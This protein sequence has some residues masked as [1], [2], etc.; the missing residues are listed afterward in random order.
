MIIYIIVLLI[1]FIPEF[2]TELKS[3]NGKLLIVIIVGLFICFGYM[4]G[5]DWR[6]YEEFYYSIDLNYPFNN[7]PFE[8]G[9]YFYILLFRY[10]NFDFW[11][12]FIFTKI[13]LYIINI[14]FL[15]KYQKEHFYISF[16]IYIFL[17]G[18]SL[19][20]DNPMRTLIA[21]TIFLFSYK[22]LEAGNI[23]TYFFIV[24]LASSF[25][26]VALLFITLYW[27]LR[28]RFVT[29]TLIISFVLFNIILW[30]FDTG[31]KN[32]FTLN[33]G[34]P[35]VDNKLNFYFSDGSSGN[36]YTENRIVS[37]GLIVR[38]V[39]FYFVLISRK[40]IE[41]KYGLIFFN[42]VISGFF[43]YR[44]AIGIPIFERF[45][46][47]VVIP[48]CVAI[49]STIIS[50][51]PNSKLI[52]KLSLYLLVLILMVK[53]I[54]MD[55]KYIPYTNYLIYTFQGKKLSF[56]E[57]SSYNFVNSPYKKK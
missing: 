27:L 20:I 43:F 12:F 57:R 3:K 19:Y 51:K 39:L 55:Y 22:H 56:D 45:E 5:S 47:F 36:I 26:I 46:L 37:F 54:T 21:S 50:F 53:N 13:I 7:I 42:L 23:K 6:Y 11:T 24:L 25:H 15:L 17:F 9:F 35:F 40:H 2:I 14:H 44:L 41:E 38:Y 16:S 8:Y 49:A 30:I 29:S 10:L 31:I 28:K 33:S 48:F 32:I 18:L 4:N 1:C 52:Y 34:I